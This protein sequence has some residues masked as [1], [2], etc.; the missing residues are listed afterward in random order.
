MAKP[1]SEARSRTRAE[2]NS[3]CYSVRHQGEK[4]RHRCHTR[5]H[6]ARFGMQ[7]H[8]SK[9]NWGVIISKQAEP[10]REDTG[11][12]DRG[13]GQT[14]RQPFLDIRMVVVSHTSGQGILCLFSR[15]L[16]ALPR[17]HSPGNMVEP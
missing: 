11:K 2:V 1:K 6:L 14:T 10:H 17:R 12:R 13:W 8:F 4:P 9:Y 5:P 7:Y 16:T 3:R 15:N